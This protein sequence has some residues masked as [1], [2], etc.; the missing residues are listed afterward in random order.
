MLILG[1]LTACASKTNQQAPSPD[2]IQSPTRAVDNGYIVYV[3]TGEDSNRDRARFKAEGAALADLAN[4]CSFVPKGTRIE[5]RFDKTEGPLHEGY[6]KVALEFQFCEEAKKTVDPEGVRKLASAPMAEQIKKYQEMLGPGPDLEQVAR[7]AEM[8]E[9]PQLSDPG[10]SSLH[11]DFHFYVVR[12]QVAYEKQIVILSPPSLYQPS[13]PETL[14]YNRA[15]VAPTQQIASYAAAHPNLQKT[16]AAWSTQVPR[17]RELSR[18]IDP[19]YQTPFRQP[20]KVANKSN[21]KGEGHHPQ[22]QNPKK[23]RKKSKDYEQGN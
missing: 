18:K 5:D 3:G 1:G 2:W 13:A 23:K 21:G 11:S 4:E 7:A 9:V 14:A 17:V 10:P 8:E 16:P 20:P 15:V 12:Q 22:G 19:H 6:A